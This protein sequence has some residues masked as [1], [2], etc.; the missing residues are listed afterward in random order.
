MPGVWSMRLWRA[1]LGRM[2]CESE[3]KAER[4]SERIH[5]KQE[6]EAAAL[7]EAEAAKW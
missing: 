6:R 4:E 2:R 5:R 3:R 7:A 1:W